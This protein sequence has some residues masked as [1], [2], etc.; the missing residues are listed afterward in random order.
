MLVSYPR[1]VVS[2][3][4][5]LDEQPKPWSVAKDCPWPGRE[6]DGNRDRYEG[7][8]HVEVADG[9]EDGERKPEIEIAAH[10][11]AENWAHWYVR[12]HHLR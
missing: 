9:C 6:C 5:I 12:P 7:E 11:A 1:P 3:G 8:G 2:V 10:D 4:R